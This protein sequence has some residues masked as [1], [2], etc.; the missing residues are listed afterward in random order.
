MLTRSAPFIKPQVMVPGD[1][2]QRFGPTQTLHMIHYDTPLFGTSQVL[3]AETPLFAEPARLGNDDLCSLKE[4]GRFSDWKQ[5]VVYAMGM[6]CYFNQL[7]APEQGEAPAEELYDLFVYY[8]RLHL[9]YQDSEKQVLWC[10][11]LP[12]A[13][14]VFGTTTSTDTFHLTNGNPIG[15]TMFTL[16]EPLVITPQKTFRLTLKWHSSIQNVAGGPIAQADPRTRFNEAVRSQKLV[17]GYLHGI[18]GREICN[19]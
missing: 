17:R 11:Q 16:K 15:N 6:Q 19:G 5:F 9:R 18:E 7:L 3:G 10:D 8:S 2:V 13:G 1:Q 14:G 4:A 12:S